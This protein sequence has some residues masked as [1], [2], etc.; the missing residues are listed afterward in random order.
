MT[1]VKEN[2]VFSV[3]NESHCYQCQKTI[4]KSN[5]LYKKNENVFCMTCGGFGDLYFLYSGNAALTRR[6]KKYS[7][8]YAV[9]LKFSRV[10]KRYERQGLLLEKAAIMR[11]YEELGI[12][13]KESDFTDE[14]IEDDSLLYR[15]LR[16]STYEEQ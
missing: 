8:I 12:E 13:F 1:E 6:A 2:V 15:Q 7:S 9:V 14:V 16:K 3:L 11:A 4:P 10:R 5:F